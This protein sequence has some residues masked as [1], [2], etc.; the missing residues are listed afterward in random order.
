MNLIYR[1]TIKVLTV[2]FEHKPDEQGHHYKDQ[3]AHTDDEALQEIER[4][5]AC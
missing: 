2:S 5:A 3:Q 1:F 4:A